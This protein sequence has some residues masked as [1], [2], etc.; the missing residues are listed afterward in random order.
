MRRN[1]WFDHHMLVVSIVLM[2]LGGCIIAFTC[3]LVR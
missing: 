2:M 3:S 1:G